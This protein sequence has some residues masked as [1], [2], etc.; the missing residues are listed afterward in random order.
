MAVGAGAGIGVT[1][2]EEGGTPAG[3]GGPPSGG[4]GKLAGAGGMVVTAGVATVAAGGGRAV[5]EVVASVFLMTRVDMVVMT[6][7]VLEEEEDAGAGVVVSLASVQTPTAAG[8]LAE[9]MVVTAL[10][11]FVSVAVLAAVGAGL[12]SN[13]AMKFK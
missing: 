10:T 4:G 1:A 13:S 11:A 7:P 5:L 2:E 9:R 6:D 8:S 12:P 3:A